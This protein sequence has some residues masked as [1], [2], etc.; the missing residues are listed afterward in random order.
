MDNNK[1]IIILCYPKL[2]IKTC[3]LGIYGGLEIVNIGN[4]SP[5]IAVYINL[6]F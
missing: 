6:I 1:K 3:Y 2:Y 4:V 5:K